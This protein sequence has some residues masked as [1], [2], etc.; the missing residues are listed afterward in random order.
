MHSEKVAY[1][2][3][4]DTGA[5]ELAD[6]SGPKLADAAEKEGPTGGSPDDLGPK[7]VDE[8]AAPDAALHLTLAPSLELS[9]LCSPPACCRSAPPNGG[10]LRS[11]SSRERSTVAETQR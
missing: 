11:A 6:D 7:L 10:G 9:L 8:K 1:Q 5:A 2:N 3:A 4:A